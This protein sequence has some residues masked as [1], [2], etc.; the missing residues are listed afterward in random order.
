MLSDLKVHPRSERIFRPTWGHILLVIGL[1]ATVAGIVLASGNR[2]GENLW[3]S[4]S[5]RER[6]ES[7]AL[8]RARTYLE[9]GKAPQTI[10]AVSVIK[11]GSP[12]EVDALTLQGL[13]LASL[14]ETGPAR[15]VLERAWHLRPSGDA[16]KVL[17]AIYLSANETE[18]GLQMLIEASRLD[19]SDF[20]PWYAMGESV[21]LRLNRYDLA[22]DAFRESLTRHTGHAESRI[23]LLDALARSHRVAEAANVLEQVLQERPDDPRVLTLAA[24]FANESG[25]DERA[26]RHLTRALAIKPDYRQALLLHARLLFRQGHWREA[27]P[28]AQKA[29]A[30]DPNDLPTLTLLSAIQSALGSTEQSRQ[31]FAHKQEVQQ[32]DLL[33]AKLQEEIMNN[34]QAP[35]PRWRL[36]QLAAQ[37]NMRPLAIQCYQAA[38]AQAPDF[39]PARQ[40]LLELG[41]PAAKLPAA[42][43]SKAENSPR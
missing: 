2:A 1:G 39:T 9:Q 30:Q 13:A 4:W 25:D 31:T 40:A 7:E 42:Q 14:E 23:G 8:A 26:A 27:L 5:G 15:Q 35:E 43:R 24:E 17:A 6:E 20:R 37:A 16:A 32:R 18:R 36:G 21:Y 38:L 34:P 12:H 11:P 29:S 28:E 22:V 10:R 33:M 19:P 41:F 3:R